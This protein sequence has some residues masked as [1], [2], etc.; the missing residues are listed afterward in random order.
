MDLEKVTG[1]PRSSTGLGTEGHE[2]L[3]C[4]AGR[5][6]KRL[7]SSFCIYRMKKK[8]SVPPTIRFAQFL[9]FD[10]ICDF[11]IRFTN[12]NLT[13]AGF[14]TVLKATM[15]GGVE[16]FPPSVSYHATGE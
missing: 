6:H 12:Q 3:L 9:S 7:T 5:R 10:S 8:A 15:T 14:D 11:N 4:A 13:T 1:Y 16:A 2:S